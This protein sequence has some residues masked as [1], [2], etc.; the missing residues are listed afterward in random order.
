ME[1]E[2]RGSS[3]EG[4]ANK[5]TREEEKVE[6][7]LSRGYAEITGYRSEKA[8][9]IKA[10]LPEP[11]GTT[12]NKPKVTIF[13]SYAHD[14]SAIKESF[15]DKIR[16]RLKTSKEYH[17]SFSSD[18][19]ILTG[20]RWHDEIQAMIERC[21]FGLLLLSTSFLGSKYIEQHELPHLLNK[22]LPV[23]LEILDLQYQNLKGLNEK[24][25]FFFK[26]KA[27]L[28]VRGPNQTRFI[29]ELAA[30]IEERVKK[31][32]RI[33]KAAE[34]SEL[35]S[36]DPLKSFSDRLLNYR[37]GIYKDGE[38]IHGSG[39]PSQIAHKPDETLKGDTVIALEYIKSWALD[40][41]LPLFAL[42]GDFGTGKTFTCRMLTRDINGVHTRE[43]ERYPL[44]IYIDLRMVSTK[45][46]TEKRIP[47]LLDILQDAIENTKDP[48]DRSL[49]TPQEIIKLVRENKAMIIY[50]GL[51]EKSV[52]FTPE[53]TSRFIAELWSIREIRD[54][55]DAALQGKVLISCRTHYFR[56]IFEQN[57]LFLGRDREGRSSSEYRSCTLLPFDDT[58]IREYLK[59]RLGSGEGEIERIIALFEEVHNLKELAGR[60]YALSLITEFIP[61][62]ERLQE[63]GK[64]INTATL[65]KLTIEN[66]LQRDEGK[67]EF[68]RAHKKSLMKALA[69]ELHKR[70]GGGIRAE[71]L[72]A[73]L[74]TWLYHHPVIT[75]AYSN[76]NRETL[77]KDLRTATFIIRE[78]EREFSFAHT[79]LQEYFLAGYILETL[80]SPNGPEDS[81]AFP[82]PSNETL[83]FAVEMLALDDRLLNSSV[84]A[85]ENILGSSYRKEL[86][87]LAL[88]LWMKLHER[89]MKQPNPGTTHLE[90]AD[91][92]G[93][94]IS[95]LNLHSACFD[96][97][98]LRGTQFE[99]T[100]LTASSFMS[101]CL[102]NAEFLSCNAS[103]ADFSDADAAGSIWRNSNLQE[104]EWQSADLRLASFIACNVFGT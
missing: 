104:T 70:G 16:D 27:F 39:L 59:K 84:K 88:A 25:I 33:D 30:N 99:G 31:Q 23:A 94:Q 82:L 10:E 11:A 80:S 73:W 9:Q 75:A 17:F 14:D 21:D 103:G 32:L 50:D 81:L 18:R 65:Y 57:S 53:E 4:K 51:D 96:H 78:E 24:Q 85:I 66:W 47:K 1:N 87:E 49:V 61:E 43:P 37:Q 2:E 20:E 67:H 69:G 93:W 101:A 89:G 36:G 54:K 15:F 46:G 97:A 7:T 102:I 34:K 76:M 55:K 74:D 72:E 8:V 40:S 28:E 29:N 52:H 68:S 5:Q 12:D 42:L 91:L 58:E 6:R 83:N 22:C 41:D 98:T 92:S 13:F 79:S 71:E 38:Y 26:N 100:I 64:A 62:L 45:I 95:N 56:D 60:P 44:C 77:K 48:L 63:E 35:I 3:L 19:D 86:S 90:G